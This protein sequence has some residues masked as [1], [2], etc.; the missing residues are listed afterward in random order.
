MISSR[1]IGFILAVYLP[2]PWTTRHLIIPQN[3]LQPIVV[4]PQIRSW[5]QG[6]GQHIPIIAMTAHAMS[7][8]R[9]RCL[10]VGMD[11]YVSK[12][13]EP[14]SL[15]NAIDRWIEVATNPD[16]VEKNAQDYTS[17]AGLFVEGMDEGL[18]GETN[19]PAPSATKV[20]VPV[21]QA[22]SSSNLPPA[23]YEATIHRFDGDR[24][25]M[26][27]MFQEFK[28][29]LSDRL[30]EIQTAVQEGNLNNLTRLGHNLKGV[31]LNFSAEPLANT[32]RQLEELGS[33]EDLTN[34]ATIVAQI[35]VEMKKLIEYLDI[36]PL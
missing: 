35:E 18:F 20:P 33:S 2:F 22:E 5:E 12:P 3:Y 10:E 30:R 21:S 15:F 14:G 19:V 1:N 17:N 36:H 32:A 16:V 29:H 8:D 28:D 11:D 27:E 13:I 23:D 24:A 34:A 6:K 4:V 9:E 25:F 7:G 31:S 26:K